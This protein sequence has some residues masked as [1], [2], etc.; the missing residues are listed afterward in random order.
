MQGIASIQDMPFSQQDYQGMAKA[1]GAY[2]DS[3]SP[4]QKQALSGVAQ[5]IGSLPIE[6]LNVFDQLLCRSLGLIRFQFHLHSLG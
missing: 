4:E 3:M 6:K 5:E 2:Y 1:I